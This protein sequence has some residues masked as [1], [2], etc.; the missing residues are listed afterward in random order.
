MPTRLHPAVFAFALLSAGLLLPAPASAQSI[1]IDFGAAV[2][3]DVLEGG[4]GAAAAPSIGTH[5]PHVRGTRRAAHE[6]HRSVTYAHARPRSTY[7]RGT[8]VF[9]NAQPVGG[10]VVYVAAPRP[11]PS[12]GAPGPRII[13]VEAERLDR[14][15]HG[16][17]GVSITRLGSAKI[18]RLAPDYRR[19]ATAGPALSHETA[20]GDAVSLEAGFLEPWTEAWRQDCEARH[21]SFDETLGT[22]RSIDGLRRFCT[23]EPG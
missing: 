18:I 9:A 19:T 5:A 12:L 8:G 13:D 3:E 16:P 21:P 7:F 14:T 17:G 1:G 22:Y 4:G 20:P 6:T 10:S 15:V 23:G 2:G 11:V